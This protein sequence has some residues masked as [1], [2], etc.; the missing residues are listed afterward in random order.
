MLALVSEEDFESVTD[1]H[2]EEVWHAYKNGLRTNCE[3]AA[4]GLMAALASISSRRPE[5]FEQL[6]P[7]A[8]E[9]LLMLGVDDAADIIVCA[10]DFTGRENLYMGRPDAQA[11]AWI[12][13]VFVVSDTAIQNALDKISTE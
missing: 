6:L 2:I 4:D 13:N 12:K 8:L 1:D 9:P 7:D 5:M 10:I 11:I 3:G